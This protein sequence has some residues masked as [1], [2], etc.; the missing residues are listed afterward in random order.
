MCF[1][2]LRVEYSR[3]KI[4]KYEHRRNDDAWMVSG[5]ILE[6]RIKIKISNNL[7]AV[8][9]DKGRDPFKIV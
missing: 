7:Q 2:G 1:P 6:V 5:N 9:N 8:I 3:N 4:T